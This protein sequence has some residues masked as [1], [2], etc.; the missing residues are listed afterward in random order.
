MSYKRT[1]LKVA[2]IVAVISIIDSTDAGITSSEIKAA[3]K[4]WVGT[5]TD[6]MPG[7]MGAGVALAGVM[8]FLNK[9]A[10]G[11]GAAGGVGMLWAAKAFMGDGQ[12]CLIDMAK[13]LFG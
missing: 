10:Y 12:A 3:T 5:L 4:S 1:L 7:I 2:I 6:W 13:V 9:Y 8:F 11:L